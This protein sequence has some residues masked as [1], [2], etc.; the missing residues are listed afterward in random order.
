V[1]AAVVRVP[2]AGHR[3]IQYASLA[4]GITG[5]DSGEYQDAQRS[6]EYRKDRHLDFLL[7]D[8]LAVFRCAPDHE[9]A[10]EN[11]EIA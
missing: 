4:K 2:V 6:R 1:R 11:G 9:A 3:A 10:D 8:L 7:L 5:T